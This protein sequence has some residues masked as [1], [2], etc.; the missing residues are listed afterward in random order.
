MANNA[1]RILK[2]V[3]A[4]FFVMINCQHSDSLYDIIDKKTR[5]VIV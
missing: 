3:N 5:L 1:N 2:P 4:G